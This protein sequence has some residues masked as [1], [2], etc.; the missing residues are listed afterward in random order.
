MKS[1]WREFCLFFGRE[2]CMKKF[3]SFYP[4]GK[5][6]ERPHTPLRLIEMEC[7]RSCRSFDLLVCLSEKYL[8][9]GEG[10]R[11]RKWWKSWNLP[12]F[13]VD[14]EAWIRSPR[15]PQGFLLI[16]CLERMFSSSVLPD[17]FRWNVVDHSDL[18]K[19]IKRSIEEDRTHSISIN[20]NGV[21]RERKAQR[22]FRTGKFLQTHFFPPKKTYFLQR[23]VSLS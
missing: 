20:L 19:K 17:N 16:I 12:T 7:M 5:F 23:V 18:I 10:E 3:R 13:S 21:Y 1:F 14:V 15:I 9:K 6:F 11:E 8:T 2:M 22:I 4:C